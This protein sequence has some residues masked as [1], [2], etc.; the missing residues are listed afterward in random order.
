MVS[1]KRQISPSRNNLL[2]KAE[3]IHSSVQHQWVKHFQCCYP[4]RWR[5]C[6]QEFPSC[7][8]DSAWTWWPWPRPLISY[9][10]WTSMLPSSTRRELLPHIIRAPDSTFLLSA[11]STMHK[12]LLWQRGVYERNYEKFLWV[13]SAKRDIYYNSFTAF[14]KDD[15]GLLSSQ[16][17]SSA[18]FLH[19]I[20][21]LQMS[22]PISDLAAFIS[23]PLKCLS[24]IW[25]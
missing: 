2:S 11:S 22:H 16:Y 19:G 13:Y 9:L 17:V 15:S 8:V 6:V 18:S 3:I 4:N 7:F 14:G 21:T 25:S 24:C 5:M 10:S 20:K 12:R 1:R 23:S